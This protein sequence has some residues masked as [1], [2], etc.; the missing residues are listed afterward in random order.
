MVGK[1]YT[2]SSCLPVNYSDDAFKVLDLQDPLQT[3]YTGGTILHVFLGEAKADP[4]AVKRFVKKVCSKYKLPQITVTPTFSI[5]AEH[6]YLAGKPKIFKMW[7]RNG[8]LFAS[9]RI[10]AAR[11]S[12]ERWQAGKVL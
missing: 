2:N 9:C 11:Q 5:C 3:K 1:I 4:N 6:G 7:Q 12:V 8:D 10:F